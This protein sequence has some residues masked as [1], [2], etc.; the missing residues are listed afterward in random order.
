MDTHQGTT[1]SPSAA[2]ELPAEL[3]L[4]MTRILKNPLA[5]LRASMESLARDLPADDPRSQH[6]HAALDEVMR[7]SR[8]VQD[9][10]DY[11]AP[12]E[13]NPL[14]CTADE[15][16]FSTLR[17]LPAGPR[18]RVRLARPASALSLRVDGP[19]LCMALRHLADYC[20][21]STCGELLF[22][23][24]AEHDALLFTLV[25]EALERDASPSVQLD[26]G[27]HLA[28]RDIPRMGGTLTLQRTARGATCIQIAFP[29]FQ[30]T[31]PA[32]RNG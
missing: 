12:R 1:L 7:L 10:V 22:G 23:A 16:L 8:G 6:V 18:A 32:Q 30:R 26:L 25:G 2:R 13:L 15:L 20:L 17:M 29:Q 14:N 31:T 4:T 27:L 3:G 5:A 9:L 28:G 19:Q 11:A 24:R 21:A